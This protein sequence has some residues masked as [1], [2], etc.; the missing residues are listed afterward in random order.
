MSKAAKKKS[1]LLGSLLALS[2]IIISLPTSAQTENPYQLIDFR[3]MRE[4]EQKNYTLKAPAQRIEDTVIIDDA[5]EV[6]L[7]FGNISKNIEI[8]L[9]SPHGDRF[10]QRTQ[11]STRFQSNF[12]IFSQKPELV[13]LQIFK[14][15]KPQPG[16]WKY[17]IQA[18]NATNNQ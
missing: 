7:L 2:A 1:Q 8:E 9:I 6:N 18:T 11:N 16:K 17:I 4:Q 10:S 14:L 13:G 15:F 12:F 3:R 5:S